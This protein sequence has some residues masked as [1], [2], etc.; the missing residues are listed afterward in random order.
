MLATCVRCGTPAS[1][2][3]SYS[4]GD[5]LIWLE[6]LRVSAGAGYPMCADHAGRLTPPRGWTLTDRRTAI[7]LFVPLE[8]A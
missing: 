2:H 8:V 6:D 4:Y 5:R 3:M 1:T 7:P